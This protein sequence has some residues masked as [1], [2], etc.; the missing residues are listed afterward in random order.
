MTDRRTFLKSAGLLTAALPLLSRAAPGEATPHPGAT[1]D[2]GPG[3]GLLFDAADLPRIRANLELPRFRDLHA[4]VF[5]AD[6]AAELRFLRDEIRLENLVQDFARARKLLENAA[7]AFV[8]TR[9]AAQLELAKLALRRVC[10]YSRWDYFLEGGQHTIGLQRASEATIACALALDWLG[11]EL[12]PDERTTVEHNVATKGAPAC[13]LSLYGMKYPDRVRGWTQDPREHMPFKTDM[14][15]WPLILNATNLKVI[16]TCGLGYA[17]ILLYGRHPEAEKWLN[18]ARQSARAFATMFGLDGAYDEGVGYWGY[19]TMHLILFAEALYRRTGLDDRSLINYPGTVRYALSMAMPTLGAPPAPPDPTKPY[20]ATPQGG[21]DPAR[22]VV[23]FSDSGLALDVS[24][25]PWVGRAH[26][27]PLSNYVAKNLG[28]MRL[29]QAAIWYRP[30]APAQAPGPELHDVHLSNDLV[31]SRTGWAPEDG[32]VALRSG[33]PANHEHADRN[34]VIFKAYGERLFHDPARAAYVTSSPR[35]LLRLTEAHTAVLI[36][37]KGHQYHDGSEGTNSSWASARVTDYRTGKGWM[38]V[39]SDATDAYQLVNPDVAGVE[40]TLVY[41][42]PDVLLLLDRV[43]LTSAAATVQV[44]YQVFND[45][46]RGA[47]EA[48]ENQFSITRPHATLAATVHSAS[49][50]TVRAGQLALPVEEGVQPFAEVGSSAGL[51]H[52][53]LTVATAQTAGGTHGALAVTREDAGWRVR[54]SH[55]GRPVEVL[56]TASGDGPPTVA[57]VD[58]SS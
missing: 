26:A 36:N 40:R 24:V 14:R 45:D 54:G 49:T 53:I 4:T 35:W 30:D 18:L 48:K 21:L 19:T 9:D 42:K 44:R 31:I 52:E 17:A 1:E 10:D 7:F 28:G 39:T 34:S 16:P 41:L 29:L 27:D 37:G 32:V 47:V 33:G 51:A 5:P 15:R 38:R 11:N 8:L 20:N 12:T 50:L 22:D 58:R 23:N 2:F 6:L 55:N 25:A 13:Y 56:I 46:G 43:R 57:V 3:R